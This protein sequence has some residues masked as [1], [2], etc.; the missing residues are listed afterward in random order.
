[1]MEGLI[2]MLEP[3]AAMHR[4]QRRLGRF[5]RRVV[6]RHRLRRRGEQPD[7]PASGSD[8]VGVA[9]QAGVDAVGQRRDR[10]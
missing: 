2:G 5:G 10:V 6:R 9:E 8:L 4:G 1:M 7:G 3:D